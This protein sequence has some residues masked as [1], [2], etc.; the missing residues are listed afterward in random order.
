MFDISTFSLDITPPM[1]APL[2]GGSIKPANAVDDPQYG[3]G[4]VLRGDG[5][6]IVL[7]TMDCVGISNHSHD[8]FVAAL[9]EAAQ[10]N[11]QRVL[12]T[13]VHQHDALW[14]DLDVQRRIDEH[15]LDYRFC[16]PQHFER[17]LEGTVQAVHDALTQPQRI[18]HVGAGRAKVD[19]VAA[20][21]RIFGDDGKV[22]HQRNT[23]CY[24]PEIRAAPEGLIDPYLT[25]L[26]FFDGDQPVVTISHYATHPMSHYGQGRVSADFCGLARARRQAEQPKCF[27]MYVTGCAGNIGVGKYNDGDPA[28]RAVLS[29]RMYVAMNEAAANVIAQPLTRMRCRHV[30]MRLPVREDPGFTRDDCES[31]LRRGEDIIQDQI[32]FQQAMRTATIVT[33]D[34]RHVVKPL[35]WRQR[36]SE[37]IDV[38]VIDFGVAT[39]L[40]LPGEPFIEYQLAAQQMRPD[41]VVIV[42][43]YGNGGPGYL[44]TDIAYDQGGYESKLPAYTGRGAEAVIRETLQAALT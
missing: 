13:C 6:P 28:N 40:L 43:G 24:D 27:Q 23:M 33:Q 20:N 35:Q 42:M 15:G 3:L 32:S 25:A 4:F 44:C 17:I 12:L 1:G 5:D 34:L 38:P 26:T 21:R 19:R 39:L 36:A 37:P 11:P 30:P 16:D 7:V 2:C 29:D 8:R 14:N 22:K 18:T 10:T 9:V 31:T 41:D